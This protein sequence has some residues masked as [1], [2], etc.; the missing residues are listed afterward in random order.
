MNRGERV[1]AHQVSLGRHADQDEVITHP[2]L[3]TLRPLLGGWVDGP[4]ARLPWHHGEG[5]A[6]QEEEE[7]E[8][9]RKKTR[10]L[11]RGRR[12]GEGRNE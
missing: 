7:E 2:D 9:R 4:P 5:G 1:R 12:G 3:L 11:E 8:R 10:R 6:Q